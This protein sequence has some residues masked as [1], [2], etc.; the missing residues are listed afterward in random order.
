MGYQLA[1]PQHK[2][3]LGQANSVAS[4]RDP[5]LVCCRENKPEVMLASALLFPE[6]QGPQG[7]QGDHT[8]SGGFSF[9]NIIHIPSLGSP[10]VWHNHFGLG[11]F[12][13]VSSPHPQLPGEGGDASSAIP[14][15]M[16]V[17]AYRVSS[18]SGKSIH[19][20]LVHY[21]DADR[22]LVGRSSLSQDGSDSCEN[23]LRRLEASPIRKGS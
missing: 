2:V 13:E 19:A 4:E 23:G 17:Q 6:L 12:L 5:G 16:P 1:R 22:P 3:N 9:G 15:E 11:L 14:S 18:C 7:L 21:E 8:T 20:T 10:S